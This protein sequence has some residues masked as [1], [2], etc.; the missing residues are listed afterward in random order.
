MERKKLVAAEGMVLCNGVV[1]G[2]E[3]YPGTE[4]DPNNWKEIPLEE[5]E[6][7]CDNSRRNGGMMAY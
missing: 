5:A 3:V 6:K 7:L 4:D 1:F 2:R